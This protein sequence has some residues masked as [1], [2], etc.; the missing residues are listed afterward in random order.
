MKAKVLGVD[1][2]KDLAVLVIDPK[3]LDEEVT[4]NSCMPFCK[5]TTQISSICT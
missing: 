4:V 1:E 5:I 3:T 2:D